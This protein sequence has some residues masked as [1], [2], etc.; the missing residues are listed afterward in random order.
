M[1]LSIFTGNSESMVSARDGHAVPGFQE[2]SSF[3]MRQRQVHERWSNPTD[4]LQ[5][6][7]PH[8]H[9]CRR[10]LT[11]YHVYM[12]DF[13]LNSV[14]DVQ[15]RNN[16]HSPPGMVRSITSVDLQVSDKYVSIYSG[17]FVEK[18]VSE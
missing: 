13:T 14:A 18:C 12:H 7:T 15:S 9:I 6:W 3:S 4:H 17:Q 2:N 8:Q 10:P 11:D 1:R 5:A 16:V